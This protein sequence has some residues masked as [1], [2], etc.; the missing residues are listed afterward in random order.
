MV[1]AP[2]RTFGLLHNIGVSMA[3]GRTALTR[4]P[5]ALPSSA[6]ERV[7]DNRAALAAA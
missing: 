1:S 2:E 6:D 5:F 7:N 4:R 3:P